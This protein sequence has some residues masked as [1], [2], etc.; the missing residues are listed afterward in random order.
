MLVSSDYLRTSQVF[1][2]AFLA[3]SVFALLSVVFKSHWMMEKYVIIQAALTAGTFVFGLLI[4]FRYFKFDRQSLF[5]DSHFALNWPDIQKQIN[6]S[7]FQEGLLACAHG[8][9]DGQAKLTNNFQELACIV[10]EKLLD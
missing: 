2:L 6:I 9:Y 3:M 7:E 1:Y 8:K 4:A 10:P 5:G